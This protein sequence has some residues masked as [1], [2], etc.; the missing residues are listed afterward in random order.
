M[1]WVRF[2]ALRS[3]SGSSLQV[4]VHNSVKDNGEIL[5]NSNGDRY[6]RIFVLYFS[7]AR[8]VC[9]IAYVSV[10][11]LQPFCFVFSSCFCLCLSLSAFVCFSVCMSIWLCYCLCFVAS[12][13]HCICLRH[14]VSVCL[15]SLLLP[16]SYLALTVSALPLISLH[17]LVLSQSL[18]LSV[19]VL[20]PLQTASQTHTQPSCVNK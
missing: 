7:A 17:T 16:V 11:L 15:P 1:V 8:H 14:S 10:L 20:P 3:K 4:P 2:L 13:A 18:H 9:M 19:C 12:V 6:K 5:I